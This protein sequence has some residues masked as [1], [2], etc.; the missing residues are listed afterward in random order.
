MNNKPI[1]C[2][3]MCIVDGRNAESDDVTGDGTTG[4]L[5]VWRESDRPL[6]ESEAADWCTHSEHKFELRAAA[7]T[8][9]VD[10]DA[11]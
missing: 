4:I 10:G 6:A 2:L 3:V 1:K 9:D 8:F 5:N 11:T 7:L